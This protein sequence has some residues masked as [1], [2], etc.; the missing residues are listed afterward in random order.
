MKKYLDLDRIQKLRIQNSAKNSEIAFDFYILLPQG[1]K[2]GAARCVPYV[3]DVPTS[4][5]SKRLKMI[6]L[7]LWRIFVKRLAD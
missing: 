7:H 5:A 1:K 3:F 2:V 4:K 6:L